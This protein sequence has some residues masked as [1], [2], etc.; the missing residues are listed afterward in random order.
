MSVNQKRMDFILL[1]PRSASGAARPFIVDSYRMWS[2]VWAETFR[3]LDGE[4]ELTSDNF[5]RQNEIGVLRF[6]GRPIGSVSF[7]RLNLNDSHWRKDSSVK[8][9]PELKLIQL[10]RKYGSRPVMVACYFVLRPEY[11]REVI[12]CSSK[13]LLLA[14][15]VEHF[16]NS[17]CDGMIGTARADRGMHISC[18]DVGAQESVKGIQYH[19]V[20]VELVHWDREFV[21]MSSAQF[22]LRDLAAILYK[23]KTDLR[24]ETATNGSLRAAIGVKRSA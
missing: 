16:L 8:S 14:L 3:E 1:D 7:I 13:R 18:Y 22:P 10:G 24:G 11:R 21:L 15:T 9:W 2:E 6:D 5:T 17:D 4:T 19:G 12:G 23:N 20:D